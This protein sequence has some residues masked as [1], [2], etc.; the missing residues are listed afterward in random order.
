MN[1][2]VRRI[3]LEALVTKREGM[4]AE[5][6]ARATNGFAPVYIKEAF[7]GLCYLIKELIPIPLDKSDL[8]NLDLPEKL[9]EGLHRSGIETIGQLVFCD[10]QDLLRIKGI[11]VAA[12]ELIIE[13]LK[14]YA[15]QKLR[16]K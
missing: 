12:V 14:D 5:N 1:D 13:A 15:L 2:L 3:E 8:H 10:E 7:D 4:L 16:G 9:I 11:G 6:A